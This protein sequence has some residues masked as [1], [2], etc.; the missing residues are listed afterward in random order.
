MRKLTLAAL[1]AAIVTPVLADASSPPLAPGDVP[2]SEA[3]W[4]SKVDGKTVYYFIDGQFF[5]REYYFADSKFAR[6]QH[7]SGVCLEGTWSYAAENQSFCYEWPT[8]TACFYHAARGEEIVILPVEPDA[9]GEYNMQ[10]VGSIVPGG[11]DCQTGL[12]S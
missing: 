6:F 2:Y 11:F 4:R 9:D 8:N 5:G 7:V 12:T 10:T 3:E 1:C